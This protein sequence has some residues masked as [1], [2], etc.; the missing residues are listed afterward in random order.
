VIAAAFTSFVAA[1]GYLICSRWPSYKFTTLSDY[2]AWGVS[3]LIGSVF[4]ATMPIRLHQRFLWLLI[5]IPAVG[6][7][8]FFFALAFIAAVFDD[9]L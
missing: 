4:V 1:S 8:L 2:A 6:A 9:G 5:Y 3:I 7:L